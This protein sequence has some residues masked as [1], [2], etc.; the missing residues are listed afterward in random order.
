M[1]QDRNIILQ[2]Q[3]KTIWGMGGCEASEV[4]QDIKHELEVYFFSSL[5]NNLNLK[6]VK[7]NK[8]IDKRQKKERKG[9]NRIWLLFTHNDWPM[10]MFTNVGP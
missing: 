8:Y 2:V 3:K 7:I 9:N 10:P 4:M 5:V 6:F 1:L